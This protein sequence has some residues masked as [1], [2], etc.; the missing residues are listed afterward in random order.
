VKFSSLRPIFCHKNQP[1]TFSIFYR[2]AVPFAVEERSGTITVVSEMSQ[3]DRTL[4]DFE[5]VANV[6]KDNVLVTNVTIHVVQ[7]E[8]EAASLFK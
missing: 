5:A 6:T 3:Y 2:F 7:P 8:D 1:A 4:Y